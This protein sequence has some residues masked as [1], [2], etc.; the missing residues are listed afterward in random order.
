MEIIK[1]ILPWVQIIVAIAVVVAILLQRN[2][3]ALGGVFGGSGS[4]V[5]HTKRGLERGLFVTTV[6]LAILFVITAIL[7]FL[8]QA[9]I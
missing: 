8:L 2:D 5:A 9:T 3:A 4:S 6:V 7:S 1:V